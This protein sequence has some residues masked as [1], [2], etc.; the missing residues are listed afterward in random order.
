MDVRMEHEGVE[1]E[2]VATLVQFQE[3]WSP[4]GW[5]L[6]VDQDL[7]GGDPPA[8]APVEYEPAEVGDSLPFDYESQED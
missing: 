1:G 6:V 7:S 2:A 8:P 4:L 5:T 3:V